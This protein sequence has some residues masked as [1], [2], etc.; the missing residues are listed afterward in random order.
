[1]TSGHGPVSGLVSCEISKDV[2]SAGPSRDT[3][4]VSTVSGNAEL[5]VPATAAPPVVLPNWKVGGTC[6]ELTAS[7]NPSRLVSVS[8]GVVGT[9]ESPPPISTSKG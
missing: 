2:R 7:E 1:M 3:V 5:L 6:G 4:L 9:T 8:F